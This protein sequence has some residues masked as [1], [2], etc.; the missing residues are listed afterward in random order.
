MSHSTAHRPASIHVHV[1]SRPATFTALVSVLLVAIASTSAQTPPRTPAEQYQSLLEQYRRA[2]SGGVFSDEERLKF[3]GRVF[4]LRNNLA[5]KFLELAEKYPTDPIAVDAL[6]QAVWQVNTVPWPVELVGTSDASIRIFALLQRD[7][8]QSAKLG[9][10]CQRLSFGF[11]KEYESFLRAAL[12]KN[13]HHEVRAQACLALAH[14]LSNRLQRLNLIEARPEIA[15]EFEDLFGKEYLDELQRQDRTKVTTE[16][17]SFFERA[18]RKYGDVKMP[19][20]ATVGQKA[21]AALFEIR[22]LTVGSQAPDIEGQDRSGRVFK[23]SD[24]RGKVVLLDFWSE[25]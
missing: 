15:Q 22:H 4:K 8:I 13:P 12:E 14:Y 20:G 25:Y 1:N 21:E 18:A 16:A 19:G 3:V 24:Y 6:M 23:L 11:N 7:H 2:A 5:L 17:E 9:Q 10:A